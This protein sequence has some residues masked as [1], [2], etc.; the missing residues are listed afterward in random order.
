MAKSSKTENAP[1]TKES[2]VSLRKKLRD[3]RFHMTGSREKNVREG[4][5]IRK[6]IARVL[7][8]LNSKENK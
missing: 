7:T 1:L 8:A 2:L 4:L 6:N 3:F 5:H